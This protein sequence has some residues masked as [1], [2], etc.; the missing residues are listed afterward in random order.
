MKKLIGIF[1]FALIFW[2]TSFAQNPVPIEVTALTINKPNLLS[3][4]Y[5]ISA[6]GL[7]QPFS[8]PLEGNSNAIFY[9][10][11]SCSPCYLGTSFIIGGGISNQFRPNGSPESVYVRI[12]LTGNPSTII[13]A[14][15][16]RLRDNPVV[17]KKVSSV[18][19]KIEVFDNYGATLIAYDNDVELSGNIETEFFNYRF[20]TL[21]ATRRIFDFRR[22]LMSYSQ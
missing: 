18:K 21:N 12:T 20:Q 11:E 17:I 6:T 4:Q 5:T 16:I 1:V 13:L 19:G 22:I 14:P 3:G 9:A 10:L 2:T 8:S 7:P 15:T